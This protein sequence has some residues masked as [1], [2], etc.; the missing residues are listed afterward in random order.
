MGNGYKVWHYS[1]SLLHEKFGVVTRVKILHNKRNTALIQMTSPEEAQRA[2]NEQ[3]KLNRV[4]TDI[5]VNFSSKFSEIRV[6]EPGSLFDDG[7][8]KDFTGEYPTHGQMSQHQHQHQQP[9]RQQQGF[10]PGPG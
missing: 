3:D 2:V 1:G 6:P 5:Y 7:L 10:G 8:T 9:P 4:G